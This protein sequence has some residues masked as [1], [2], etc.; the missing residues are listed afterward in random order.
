M[1]HDMSCSREI[2][3][4]VGD[5]MLS[6]GGGD[7]PLARGR[8]HCNGRAIMFDVGKGGSRSIIKTCCAG[9]GDGRFQ[10]LEVSPLLLIGALA[11]ILATLLVRACSEGKH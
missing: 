11:N 4:Q 5:A 10:T 6:R 1:L 9:V 3:G 8:A 7:M 2:C